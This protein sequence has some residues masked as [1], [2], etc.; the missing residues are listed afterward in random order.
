MFSISASRGSWLSDI[1]FQPLANGISI[2]FST[3]SNVEETGPTTSDLYSEEEL[4]NIRLQEKLDEYW[5]CTAGID[6]GYSNQ[7]CIK[8]DDKH[9]VFL[10]YILVLVIQE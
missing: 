4:G 1:R 8:F 2:D 6:L 10:M 5:Y 7:D 3:M 9:I